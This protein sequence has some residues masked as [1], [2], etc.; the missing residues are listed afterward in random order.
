MVEVLSILGIVTKEVGQGRT[1]AYLKKLIG[2]KDVE[3]AL[4]R[5][6]ALTQEEARMAAAEALTITRGIDDKVKE[7]CEKVEG[8]DE[9]VQVVDIKVD[10]IDDKV[11]TVDGKVQCVD[12]KV[13]SV[14]RGVKETGVA[15]QQVANQVTNL[16]RN[17]LRKDL[18]KWIAPPDPSVNYNTASGARHEGTAT[19][20]TEGITLTDW[21]ASGSLLWIHGKPGSGKS[22]LSSVIVRDIKFMSDAGSAFLAYFY[23]DFKDT[24]KQDSRSLLSS[25]LVQLSDQSDIFCDALS[26]LYSTHKRGSQQP[27]VDSLAQCLRD[28]LTMVGRVPIYLIMDALDESPNNSGI[29]TSRENVLELVKELA[30]LSYP[31]L[32]LCITSRPEYDIRTTLEPLATHQVSLHDENG[33]KQDIDNYVTFVVHS[34]R[35]MKRWREDDKDAVIE[36]LTEKADGMFRW[37]FC[38]LEVLR[39]CFP[40]NLRRIL[41]ELPKSLDETYK[42]ILK[43][44]NNANREHAYRLLQC[45]AVAS[46]PLRVEEL[47]EVLAFDLS[48]GGIPKLIADWRWEDQEEAVLSACS[49]L[50]S[51]IVDNGS[52]RVVQFSH[53]S[54]KEFLIS[55]RLASCMEEVSRFYIPIEPCHV[56]I[57]QACLGVLLRLDDGTDKDS[58][59]KIPLVQYAAE[60]WDLH[61]ETGNV[62]LQIKDTMDCFF[63]MDK[64]HFSAWAQVR[65]RQQSVFK[66]TMDCF[67]DMDKSHFSAWAQVRLRQQSV[68]IMDSSNHQQRSSHMP[69]PA[70]PLCFAAQKGF[71][72]LVERLIL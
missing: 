47:A 4:Q 15:I 49:S 25:L 7:M 34:D 39:H 8:V 53:F 17:E 13:G 65:L 9:R 56:I 1:K 20:C 27:T 52:R 5:L 33:Q 32:R 48:T 62:E 36:N 43:E 40:T 66:D 42:R 70:A 41:E 72:S 64:S 26:S 28:M 11:Q 37:V 31:N 3:D 30:E 54:V 71:R 14:I 22:I 23:F 29:P 6:D 59:E 57:A 69:F 21:K 44:I 12:H 19:W 10:G 16:N 46:R 60:Y 63:D 18:R 38:Q 24:T 2:R 35:R 45:L 55:D 68:F 50:V 58:A 67:F 61:A 51:V